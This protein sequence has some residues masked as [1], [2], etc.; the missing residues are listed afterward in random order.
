MYSVSV[1]VNQP[2]YLREDYIA[3]FRLD[4]R[5]VLIDYA[6]VESAVYIVI[7]FSTKC[8]YRNTVQLKGLG[9]MQQRRGEAH[10]Q[11]NGN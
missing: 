2:T 6:V 1:E 10:D 8:T 11:F 9:W 7:Q 3:V 4:R 5:R